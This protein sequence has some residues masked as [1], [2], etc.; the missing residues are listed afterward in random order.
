MGKKSITELNPARFQYLNDLLSD[1]KSQYGDRILETRSLFGEVTLIDP[2]THSDCD[3]GRGSATQNYE[4]A[5]SCG[6]DCVFITDHHSIDS[7]KYA[8]M[9]EGISWGQEPAAGSEHLVVLNNDEPLKST[10]GKPSE[11]YADALRRC[12]FAF[13]PHPAGQGEIHCDPDERARQLIAFAGQEFA[14]EILNGLFQ[15]FRCWNRNCEDAVTIWDQLLQRG[16]RVSPIGGSDAH[17]PYSIGTAWTGV[18]CE[19]LSHNTILHTLQAGRC[20]ASEAA[21]LDFQCCGKAAGGWLKVSPGQDLLFQLRAA[22]HFGLRRVRLIADGIPLES[23][24]LDDAPL[25]EEEF[26]IG[27]SGGDRYFRMEAV[28]RDDRRAFSAPLYLIPAG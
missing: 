13:I 22:D 16:C 19:S 18:L 1:F 15:A 17:D 26:R 21:M 25:F 14:M 27:N 2:H 7:R 10:T 9:L 5:M 6:L 3:D 12:R 23:W 8:R 11:F 20:F 4:V 28:S 24:E